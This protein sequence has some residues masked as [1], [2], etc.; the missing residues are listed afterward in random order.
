MLKMQ[1]NLTFD[2]RHRILLNEKQLNLLAK[3][4]KD[5]DAKL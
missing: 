1:K 3:L 5:S 2:E 4:S